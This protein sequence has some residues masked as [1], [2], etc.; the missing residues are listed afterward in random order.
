M[1]EKEKILSKL[2][3]KDYRNELELIL[4]NKRF[5]EEAK[6]LLLSIFYK[7]DNF[8]K[9]YM[10]VK[11]ETEAKNNFLEEYINIIKNNCNDIKILSPQEFKGNKKYEIDKENGSIKCFPNEIKLLEA[12][13]NL[14]EQTIELEELYFINKCYIDLLNKGKTINNTEVI[15]D[16]NGWSWKT[17]IDNEKNMLYNLIFQNVLILFNYNFVNQNMNKKDI[18][19]IMKKQISNQSWKEEGIEIL[20]LLLKISL[21]L[22]NNESAKKHKECIEQK[23][24][25]NRNMS[26]LNNRR[27]Y[28]SDLTKENALKIKEI[29]K[30][31]II[32]ND[33][34]LIRNEFE[35]SIQNNKNKYFCISDFVDKME[36]EREKF[37]KEIEKNN[38]LLSPREYLRIQDTYKMTLEL[39]EEIEEDK[40]QIDIQ[41]KI[42]LLQKIFLDIIEIK[43]KQ[44]TTKREI[45]N[46]ATQLRYYAN[47]PYKKGKKI[48]DDNQISARYI[49]ICKILMK[50]MLEL[51]VVDTGFKNINLN[52]NIIKYIFKTK[53]MKLDGIM[54]RIIFISNSKIEVEYYDGTVIENKEIF[55]IPFDEEITNKKERKFKLLKIGG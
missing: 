41:N 26:I 10:T 2:N 31:D 19:N 7:L 3:I 29:Q 14:S 43:I 45:Y 46:L 40:K 28:I 8:Y 33:I 53:I 34:N 18:V 49:K 13:Y 27:G 55:D 5:D 36:L 25:I 23:N 39:Y 44:S 48:I 4:E 54:I 17:E 12:L 47:I 1:G 9:D 52:L 32:L 21:I 35:K 37:I 42:I 16:F 22:Y 51:K 15:R 38:N 6:S 11:K 30:I 50:K 20:N 24:K